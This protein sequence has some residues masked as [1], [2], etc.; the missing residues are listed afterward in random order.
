MERQRSNTSTIINLGGSTQN[1][2]SSARFDRNRTISSNSN[3]PQSSTNTS[4]ETVQRNST[5]SHAKQHYY[6]HN[7]DYKH[8]FANKRH[9][10]ASN[11]NLM[12]LDAFRPLCAPSTLMSSF[13]STDDSLSSVKKEVPAIILHS[14]S[15]T[16]ETEYEDDNDSTI[17][18]DESDE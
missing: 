15:S 5:F 1:H 6:R 14:G 11:F 7:P 10:V 2:I 9:T 4:P 3:T 13:D 17:I 12:L 8:M 16:E 18:F